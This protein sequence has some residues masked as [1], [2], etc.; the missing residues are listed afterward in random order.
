MDRRLFLFLLAMP[1][2]VHAA[3]APGHVQCDTANVLARVGGFVGLDVALPD[4]LDATYQAAKDCWAGHAGTHETR[5][6]LRLGVANLRR[7]KPFNQHEYAWLE[8]LAM[9]RDDTYGLGLLNYQYGVLAS[10]IASEKFSRY[11]RAYELIGRSDQASGPQAAKLA[12]NISGYIV[13][14]GYS[15]D[16]KPYLDRAF[17]LYGTLGQEE[18]GVNMVIDRCMELLALRSDTLRT[19]P[20]LDNVSA[21]IDDRYPWLVPKLLRCKASYHA[22]RGDH[23]GQV[24]VLE[25]GAV[26]CMDQKQNGDAHSDCLY[27]VGDA[28]LFLQNRRESMLAESY[29]HQ[30]H[31]FIRPDAFGHE[32]MYQMYQANYHASMGLGQKAL[33]FSEWSDAC[34]TRLVG[35]E[36]GNTRS[37]LD[38]RLRSMDQLGDLEGARETIQRAAHYNAARGGVSHMQRMLGNLAITL[39]NNGLLHEA[40]EI[41]END[42]LPIPDSYEWQRER[43]NLYAQLG[44]HDKAETLLK[45]VLARSSTKN[46]RAL[47]QAMRAYNAMEAGDLQHG[48]VWVDSAFV[49]LIGRSAMDGECTA[50]GPE[51]YNTILHI[52]IK[53]AAG[54]Q[55]A[56]FER[57]GATAHLD[58]CLSLVHDAEA[59]LA[60]LAKAGFRPDMFFK[61]ALDLADLRIKAA[62]AKGLDKSDGRHALLQAME[63]L[64]ARELSSILFRSEFTRDSLSLR[65]D[66]L[67]RALNA[68]VQAYA[69]GELTMDLSAQERTIAEQ[70]QAA[71]EARRILM[72]RLAMHLPE[73]EVSLSEETLYRFAREHHTAFL[74]HLVMKD[75]LYTLAV[76]SAGTVA[77][78]HAIAQDSLATLVERVLRAVEE[79]IAPSEGDIRDLNDWIIPTSLAT[80]PDEHLVV[81]SD[82]VLQRLPF[83]MLTIPGSDKLLM[84]RF[85]VR[86]AISIGHALRVREPIGNA[87]VLA[88]APSYDLAGTDSVAASSGRSRWLFSRSARTRA[89]CGPLA[90][91]EREAHHA[92]ARLGGLYLGGAHATELAM[93]GHAAQHGVLLLTMHGFNHEVDPMLSGLVFVNAFGSL[94][95]DTA[96][97]FKPEFFQNDGILHAFEIQDLHLPYDLVVLSACHSGTGAYRA[98][99]GTQSL[100]RAFLAA[101]ARSVVM[102]LWQVDDASTHEIINTF[103]DNLAKGMWRSEALS[104]A[105]RAF[106]EAHP[107]APPYFWSGLV[108]IGDDGP[109][110]TE[111]TAFPWVPF[112][113]SLASIGLLW[114]LLRRKKPRIAA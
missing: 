77:T 104:A 22:A 100:A 31:E 4:S 105:K 17:S 19:R 6:L 78:S 67:N 11:K 79:R 94:P 5:L 32:C 27:V 74:S 107:T 62:T 71:Q 93:S 55:W 10:R 25:Q 90:W 35:P 29:M 42:T 60:F 82:G 13:R 97:I 18:Q 68:T 65:F 89:L 58:S 37:I 80:C 46:E 102:S 12:D 109:V 24:R 49:E 86:Q 111:R 98:G 70:T 1:L 26:I 2:I 52:P 44:Q 84:D 63:T 72:D 7:Q 87:G 16:W 9:K 41:F 50:A 103:M 21:L 14:E 73:E 101:G 61:D 40:M 91:N 92:T 64:R 39:S 54:L 110:R 15:E 34:M 38:L 48:R 95:Q 113:A 3:A 36:H 57:S 112:L 53:V 30:L 69:S 96:S 99:E 83:D 23:A 20:Y 85:H 47:T 59:Q 114:Y 51:R 88:M 45:E 81:V 106:R 66:S 108:L 76:T 75:R 8:K 43:G 28:M 33:V 56:L